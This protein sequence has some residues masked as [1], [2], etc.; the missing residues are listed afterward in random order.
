VAL[1]P[2]LRVA[3]QVELRLLPAEVI[4]AR[5]VFQG[6]STDL[7]LVR[8]ALSTWWDRLVDPD[9]DPAA[10]SAEMSAAEFEASGAWL[11]TDFTGTF[12]LRRLQWRLSRAPA[13]GTSED[14]DVCTFHFIKATGGTPGTYVDG[15]D[16]PAVETALGTYWGTLKTN[17]PTFLHSDQFRWYKD[18]PAYYE[19]NGDGTAYVPIAAGNPAIRVTEVDVAGSAATAALPP[20]SAVTVTERT[21][22][23]LHWGRWYLPSPAAAVADTDGRLASGQITSWLGAAVTFYNACRAAQ[24]VPVVW[25]IQKPTRHKKNG[26]TLAPAP[27]VAYEVTSLQMD[28][29]FD[30]IRS[31]RYR[32]ATVK[33]NTALT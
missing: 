4:V 9:E 33:T 2:L 22:S 23:R 28:N 26:A 18:G 17:M 29:L 27:A 10:L 32:A 19:L 14:Q 6:G 16:L 5:Y 3:I 24:M 7:A 12:E 20:Q 1:V 21:S 8:N 15:T 31:R 13:G 25:S 30:V 11:V